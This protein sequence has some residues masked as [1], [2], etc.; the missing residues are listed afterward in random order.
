MLIVIPLSAAMSNNVSA[1]NPN[2]GVTEGALTCAKGALDCEAKQ[3][4]LG[5]KTDLEFGSDNLGFH[6]IHGATPLS[7]LIVTFI[8]LPVFG[9]IFANGAFSNS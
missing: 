3:A 5:K 9:S 6:S 8:G 4:E 7:L 1:A 2:S